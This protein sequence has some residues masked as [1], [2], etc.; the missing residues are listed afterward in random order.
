M[1]TKVLL[2]IAAARAEAVLANRSVV[3]AKLIVL[4]GL[5]EGDVYNVTLTSFSSTGGTGNYTYTGAFTPS[6]GSMNL[7]ARFYPNGFTG[8]GKLLS[9]GSGIL[10]SI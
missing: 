4:D 3:N 7:L 9:D 2:R 10:G 8:S 6:T 5:Y 1:N